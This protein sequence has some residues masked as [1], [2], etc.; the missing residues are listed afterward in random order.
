[1][2]IELPNGLLRMGDQGIIAITVKTSGVGENEGSVTL[3]RVAA[4]DVV[5]TVHGPTA[6]RFIADFNEKGSGVIPWDK[7]S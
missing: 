5:L 2:R 6:L 3:H 4:P 1:M 7:R